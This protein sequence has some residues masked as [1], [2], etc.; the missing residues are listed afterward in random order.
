MSRTNIRRL[1]DQGR[2]AGLHASQIYGA[3]AAL[4]PEG[5]DPNPEQTDENGYVSVFDNGQRTYRPRTDRN[6]HS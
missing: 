6:R 3:L 4:P 1:I 5:N 2:K